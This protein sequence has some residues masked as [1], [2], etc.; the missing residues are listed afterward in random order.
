[1]NLLRGPIKQLA[2][3]TKSAVSWDESMMTAF[4]R[5]VKDIDTVEYNSVKR[6]LYLTRNP[7]HFES[8]YNEK[9]ERIAVKYNKELA[10]EIDMKKWVSTWKK[11]FMEKFGGVELESEE[12]MIETNLECLPSDYEDFYKTFQSL[13]H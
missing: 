10:W 5:S 1:M 13:Y 8:V 4:F 2:V 12:K 11:E 9:G 3:P 7:P 6:V